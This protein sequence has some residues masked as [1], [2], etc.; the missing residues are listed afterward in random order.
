M[1]TSQVTESTANNFSLVIFDLE[2]ERTSQEGS[3]KKITGFP[4]ESAIEKWIQQLA[5]DFKQHAL[6]RIEST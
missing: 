1:V 5:E 3:K 6:F 4:S 2:K